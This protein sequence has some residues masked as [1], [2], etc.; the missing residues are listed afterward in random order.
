MDIDIR[1]EENMSVLRGLWGK[2]RE[3]SWRTLSQRAL[4]DHEA[5]LSLYFIIID[6]WCL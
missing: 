3:S 5:I 2:S 4:E 1:V 6:C